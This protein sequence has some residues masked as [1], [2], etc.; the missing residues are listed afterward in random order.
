MN[1]HTSP[2]EVVL[3]QLRAAKGVLAGYRNLLAALA[4]V[5]AL[6]SCRDAAGPDSD[7]SGTV[8]RPPR[9]TI[10]RATIEYEDDEPDTT[11]RHIVKPA[12][13]ERN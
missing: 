6:T 8:T 7:G 12:F 9:D 2:H 4:L 10:V 5:G 13:I 1:N 11:S 3:A